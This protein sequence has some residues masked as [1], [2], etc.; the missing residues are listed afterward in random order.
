M[1]DRCGDTA[2]SYHL[3]ISRADGVRGHNGT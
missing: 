3:P 1:T 2:K